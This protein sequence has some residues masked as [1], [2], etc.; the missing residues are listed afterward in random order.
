MALPKTH[1]VTLV[2]ATAVLVVSQLLILNKYLYINKRINTNL[3][4]CIFLAPFQSK[5]NCTLYSQVNCNI[6]LNSLGTYLLISYINFIQLQMVICKSQNG[7][8]GKG[9]RGMIGTRGT[10]VGRRGIRVGMRRI[11][12]ILCENLRVYCFG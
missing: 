3:K 8:S 6:A 1:V 11:S 10:I 7:E 5:L 9:M 2:E 12:V 4:G